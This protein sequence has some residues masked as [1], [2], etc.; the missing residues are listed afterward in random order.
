MNRI[1]ITLSLVLVTSAALAAAPPAQAQL[2]D[3]KVVSLEAAMAVAQAAQRYAAGRKW[4]V[5]VAVVDIAGGPILLHRMDDVQH[6]SADL[7]LGKA[8]T[9][10]RFRRPTKALADAVAGG[11]AGFLGVEG[12]VPLE[13]GVPLV[14][15]GK[16]IGAVGVS[17]LTGEQ[18][19]EVARAGAE[20]LA[21]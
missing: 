12:V 21:P 15:G 2:L 6:A 3:S 18:D 14:V 5:A 19:A 20:A 13:G 10:A 17:G 1:P 8:R 7:A 4:Q 16:V 11:R 9:S